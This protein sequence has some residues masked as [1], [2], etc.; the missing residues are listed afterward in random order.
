MGDEP[1]TA[2]E[3]NRLH[4][5]PPP[6]MARGK[7]PRRLT[8]VPCVL[9]RPSTAVSIWWARAVGNLEWPFNVIR[10]S[11]AIVQDD[12]GGK[13]AEGRNLLAARVLARETDS[14]EV[15][16]L[17]WIDDDVI[18]VSPLLLR[19]L[20]YQSTTHDKDIVAGVYF[21]KEQF[22]QPLVFPERG[23]GTVPFEPNQCFEAWGV[24]M[25]LTLVR[26]SLYRRMRDELKL[27]ADSMG[28]PEWYRTPGRDTD[29]A[30]DAEGVMDCGGTEDLYFCELAA[31]L[32]VRPVV[33]TSMHAF[34]FHYDLAERQG[35]P[36]EQWEQY[37][38]GGPIIWQTKGGPVEWR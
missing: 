1:F 14:V 33:D 13:V 5:G 7:P 10:S 16:H 8:I 26:A 31:K 15:S 25:G 29:L 36:R 28:N 21:S 19:A 23:R 27:P 9:A 37:R 35:Y 17:L 24:G 20:H 12:V 11:P 32:G 6:R 3:M 30:V 34:S 22:P 18:P 4:E 2:E 38:K